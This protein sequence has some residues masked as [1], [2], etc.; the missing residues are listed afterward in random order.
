MDAEVWFLLLTLMGS[1]FFSGTETALIS[2]NKIKLQ[3]WL[4]RSGTTGWLARVFNARPGDIL[5]TLLVGN[6]VVNILATVLISD[7]VF[8]W[9]PQEAGHSPIVSVLL[10]PVIVTPPILLFGEIL[11]KSLAR[12]HA[13]RLFPVLA[14]PLWGFYHFL[15][16][17]NR[18]VHRCAII[19]LKLIGVSDPVGEQI[20]TRKNIQRVLLES[21]REGVLHK[22]ESSYI[23]G[24]FD[25]SETMAREIMTPRTDLVAIRRDATAVEVA[26]KMS[27]SYFSRIPVYEGTLDH[28]I[29]M[30]HVVDLVRNG[31]IRPPVVHPVIFTPE[32]RKCDSLLYE[33]RQKRIHL[34]VVLDEYGGTAGIVTLEDLLEELVGDIRDVHDKRS[35]L[36]TVG[37]DRSLIVSGSTRFEDLED[38][39]DLPETDHEVETVAGL[40]M[41]ELGR[42]PETGEK[43]QLGSVRITVLE[44]SAKRI[45]RLELKQMDDDSKPDKDVNDSGRAHIRRINERGE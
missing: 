25:F 37:R 32:T 12:E 28:I 13:I 3:S 40:L 18:V 39:I 38:R 8:E 27:E 9:F 20:F 10:I 45:E 15:L 5:S 23:S 26:E 7:M 41:A 30:V 24:V 17:V 36:V 4:E 16:P 34:A 31:P 1:A 42:I 35:A 44:A 29:G 43:F 22:E 19:L 2:I 21:E 33:M 14:A 11:P 6:N